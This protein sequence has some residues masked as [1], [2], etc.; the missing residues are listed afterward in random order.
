MEAVSLGI[1]CLT[2]TF[3]ALKAVRVRKEKEK[4]NTF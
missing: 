1:A 3:D 2:I 4:G